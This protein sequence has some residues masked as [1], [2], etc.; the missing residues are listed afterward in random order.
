MYSVERG[1]GAM[2]TGD[3][4]GGKS[5]SLG[6]FN[7]KFPHEIRWS[8]DGHTL[9]ANY[10][11]T[12]ASSKG[13][14]GFLSG[15][16]GDIEPI[17]RDTNKY[18]S[19]TLSADGRPHATV[20]ARSYATVSIL[21]EGG[22]PLGE[23]RPLLSRAN[24]FDEFSALSWGADGNLLVSNP[25]RLSRLGADGKN[26]TQL[27]ADSSALILTPSSCG[28]NYL[29]LTWVFHGGTHS[30][31]I[32]RTN[33]DGSSPLKLTDGK[34]DYWPVCSLDQK[35]VYYV[36]EIATHISRVPLDGSGKTEAI[37]SM[38]QDYQAAALSISPHRTT[39]S[40]LITNRT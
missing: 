40:T 11:R 17:T 34:F 38:P 1:I 31:S 26:K 28:T 23:P 37:I 2:D 27:L 7:G 14:I 25:G 15:T 24:E 6:T 8:P 4:D 16:G 19:L 36:S 30:V 29:V 5:H 3:V 12:A 22:H 21:S 20:L 35:W 39:L 10:W 33:A 18:S 9:F 13:Q 32:W